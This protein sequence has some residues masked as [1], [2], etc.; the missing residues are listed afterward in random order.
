MARRFPVFVALALAFA[1]AAPA[2]AVFHARSVDTLTREL[3]AAV[4]AAD[5]TAFAA[6]L[7]DYDEFHEW[8]QRN[9]HDERLEQWGRDWYTG[10]FG[11][12]RKDFAEAVAAFETEYYGI[13]VSSL[14]FAGGGVLDDHDYAAFDDSSVFLWL[15]LEARWPDAPPLLY[16]VEFQ[17]TKLR[18]KHFILDFEFYPVEVPGPTVRAFAHG[19]ITSILTEDLL[20]YAALQPDPSGAVWYAEN[21]MLPDDRAAFPDEWL[22]YW[23]APLHFE[24]DLASYWFGVNL[25][26]HIAPAG[27]D[28]VVLDEFF[29]EA[30]PVTDQ[31]ISHEMEFLATAHLS[32]GGTLPLYVWAAGLHGPGGIKVMEFD[33][34][35]ESDVD[36]DQAVW[37]TPPCW[38]RDEARSR[39]DRLRRNGGDPE[40]LILLHAFVTGCLED[41]DP[42][43]YAD[44]LLGFANRLYVGD[45]GDG[46]VVWSAE[47]TLRAYELHREG[48]I[49][50]ETW[51]RLVEKRHALI[52]NQMVSCR[53]RSKKLIRTGA[54][55]ASY[56][57]MLRT[58]IEVG[59]I[60]LERESGAR[61]QLGWA[62]FQYLRHAVKLQEWSEGYD[63][64]LKALPVDERHL[65]LQP[66]RLAERFDLKPIECYA[67][68]M[69]LGY[70]ALNG[71][72]PDLER[73][74]ERG[75]LPD[76]VAMEM[77]ERLDVVDA[78]VQVAAGFLPDA[79]ETVEL[80]EAATWAH[81]AVAELVG[82]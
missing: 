81:A 1:W 27:V 70:C 9:L 2:S 52:W 41:G 28:T 49:T 54:D 14:T 65:S 44:A 22:G 5:T 26:R 13:P 36:V 11:Y 64:G 67:A 23:G 4:T 46:R 59:Q 61:G 71:F 79:P 82:R 51:E 80:R 3:A 6:L 33:W 76:S 18:D 8:K 74:R 19:L 39:Y 12:I 35:D 75:F 30:L 56:L 34:E 58:L 62:G 38:A 16:H 63:L 47:Q 73:Y 45:P 15:D 32:D 53:V 43:G 66:E 77:V 48:L 21:R 29:L 31:F 50:A 24:P 37:D 40:E 10:H 17:A 78:C 20:G 68:Y 57:T 69:G 60:M 25:K 55:P 42:A 72:V 7:P